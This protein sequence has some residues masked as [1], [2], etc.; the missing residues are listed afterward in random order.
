[1]SDKPW[2]L[3]VVARSVPKCI[4][5]FRLCARVTKIIVHT[6]NIDN[7]DDTLRVQ[8]G[9]TQCKSKLLGLSYVLSVDVWGSKHSIC[10]T[11]SDC[12]YEDMIY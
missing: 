5:D 6:N 1:M 9:A 4:S 3:P 8:T 7:I 12:F 11:K 2:L 10:P